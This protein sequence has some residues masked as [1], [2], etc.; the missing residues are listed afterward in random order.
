MKRPLT[1]AIAKAESA[2]ETIINDDMFTTSK[3]EA[4]AALLGAVRRLIT[5]VEK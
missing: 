3:P 2:I 1:Q 5:E 4:V